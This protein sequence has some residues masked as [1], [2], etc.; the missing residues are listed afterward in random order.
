M[1]YQIKCQVN[2]HNEMV[3]VC[4]DA[5]NKNIACQLARASIIAAGY[6]G[7]VIISVVMEPER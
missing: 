6:P 1:K 5:Q 2:A 3:Y 4:V 7:F